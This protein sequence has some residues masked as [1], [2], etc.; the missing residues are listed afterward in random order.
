M[1]FAVIFTLA[2]LGLLALAVNLTAWWTRALGV[3]FGLVCLLL[4]AAYALNRPGFFLKSAD[5]RIPFAG[6][7]IYW[8]YFAL[9][10]AALRLFRA[11]AGKQAFQ[12]VAGNVWLGCRPDGSDAATLQA[13]PIGA[14]LDLAAEFSESSFLR[15]GRNYRSLPILDTRAPTLA[16]LRSG[17]E[18][19]EQ[20]QQQHPIYVH[21]AIGHGRSACFVLA[22]LLR[23]HRVTS[24]EGGLKQLRD[25][26]PGVG[27][28]PEQH[29][30]LVAFAA[31]LK[32]SSP[33]N[34]AIL[35]S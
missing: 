31:D 15:H 12:L 2:G 7:L 33:D 16:Q 26:R 18:F 8:V 3:D 35:P 17:V 6:W 23:T 21:C 4:G 9:N 20:E 27:F 11:R 14:V 28:Y 25:L 19:I 30:V 24:V 1:R 22:W 29:A 10:L 13:V 34:H 5:G 32:L